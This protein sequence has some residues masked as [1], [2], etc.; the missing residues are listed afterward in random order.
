M[1][2]KRKSMTPARKA[3]ILKAHDGLCWRCDH[4]FERDEKI[5]YDHKVALCRGG[6]D[7]D[8]N[9]GPAHVL[10][11]KLKTNGTKA[12]RLGADKFE[13]AKT[14]RMKEKHARTK[15]SK[16]KW[17]SRPLSNPNLKKKLDGSVVRRDVR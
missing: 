15:Y 16:H 12:L 5:E 10:C 7:D 8:E 4:P 17:A 11:H 13:A 2:D 9:I 3:R 6:T 1:N 14:K